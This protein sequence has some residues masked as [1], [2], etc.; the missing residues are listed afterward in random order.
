[1]E[2]NMIRIVIVCDKDTERGRVRAFLTSQPDFEIPGEGKDGYDLLKLVGDLKPDIVL[3]EEHL[4]F[5]DETD[6]ISTLKHRS[7]E[8]GAIILA[9]HSENHQV[10]KAISE[11][12]SGCLLK[13]AG[14][15]KFVAGIR[16]VFNGGSLMTPEIALKAFMMFRNIPRDVPPLPAPFASLPRIELQVTKCIARGLSNKEIAAKLCLKEGTVRNYIT[17]VFQRTGLKNRTQVALQAHAA[18][19]RADE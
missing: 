17:A 15:E 18:G 4:P 1:M 19:F 12:A 14:Q 6:V 16:T 10:L 9:S 8:T 2:P 13:E 11:G 3:V 7:P 5:L